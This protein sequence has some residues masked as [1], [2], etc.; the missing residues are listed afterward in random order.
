MTLYF[1]IIKVLCMHLLKTLYALSIIKVLSE[2]IHFVLNT[3]CF[4]LK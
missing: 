3:F 4:V 1:C 2:V